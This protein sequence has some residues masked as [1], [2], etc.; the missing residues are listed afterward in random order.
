MFASRPTPAPV[1]SLA[2][3]P[4]TTELCATTD[5]GT[6]LRWSGP[7]DTTADVVATAV[8]DAAFSG[9]GRLRVVMPEGR[10]ATIEVDGSTTTQRLHDGELTRVAADGRGRVAVGAEDGTVFLLHDGEITT[11]RE[12]G[13]AIG[14]LAFHPRTTTLASGDRSGRVSL[15]FLDRDTHRTMSVDQAIQALGWIH[16]GKHVVARTADGAVAWDGEQGTPA[17]APLPKGTTDFAVSHSNGTLVHRDAD[18]VR[19]T[20]A[21]GSS[22]PLGR[23][24]QTGPIAVSGDGRWSVAAHGSVLRWWRSGPDDRGVGP[25]GEHLVPL[26]VDGV[27]VGLHVHDGHPLV[28]TSMGE[29]LLGEGESF[30][31]LTDLGIEVQTS[32]ASPEGSRLALESTSD[33]AIHVVDLEHPEQS[34]AL[35]AVEGANV[36]PLTWA[37]D[38]SAVAKLRCTSTR[39]RCR[40]SLHPIDG[41]D[42]WSVGPVEAETV[43]VHVSPTGDRVALQHVDHLTLLETDS[44]RTFSSPAGMRP[45]AADFS[46]SGAL[47]LASIA[48]AGATSVLRV[49][50]L[51]DD[52]SMQRLFEQGGLHRL[53]PT[54]ARDGLVLETADG[55]ALLWR[56]HQ[57]RFF[58]L[59][60]AVLESS[61]SSDVH[62]A[63]QGT[64][65]WVAEPGADTLISFDL[66]TDQ[67]QRWP[68]STGTPAWLEGGGWA[69]LTGPRTLRE[70]G[71]AAPRDGEAFLRWL[72]RRTAVEIPLSALQHP[73]SPPDEPL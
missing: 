48:A 57:D 54:A 39:T 46:S 38:G 1:T 60:P 21:D 62:V 73:V 26:A 45:V 30:R 72:E 66:E 37:P 51:D 15:W 31:L 65:L 25:R 52:G 68:H 59:P 19:V 35:P 32:L 55:Q 64:Q 23:A 12:H 8:V 47:R 43:A 67:H 22:F 50:Q 6:L 34:R 53:A 16:D 3:S 41:R 5:A 27:A 58:E 17:S 71:T 63:A 11:L 70:W 4:D 28:V 10:L 44:R 40:V 20:L 13:A 24:M 33:G 61:R 2:F 14:A 18:W 9:H 69:E 36:G 42:T 7:D 56:L 49:E 29:V